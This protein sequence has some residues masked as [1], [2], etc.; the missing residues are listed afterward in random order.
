VAQRASEGFEHRRAVITL[1]A[2]KHYLSQR[3]L[4]FGSPVAAPAE[5]AP[6]QRAATL[7]EAPVTVPMRKRPADLSEQELRGALEKHQGNKTRAAA[8]LGIAVN[9]LKARMK[10]LGIE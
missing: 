9:T 8:E 4:G 2:V 6:I 3:Q 5:Q 10:A 1:E 7:A